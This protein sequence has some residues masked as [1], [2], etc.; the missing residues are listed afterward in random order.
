MWLIRM[1]RLLIMVVA[2]VFVHVSVMGLI[3][4]LVI[5]MLF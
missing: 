1:M 3:W 2:W 5:S 4:S